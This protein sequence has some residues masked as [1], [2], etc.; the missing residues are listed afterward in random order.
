MV[1]ARLTPQ[2]KDAFFA[3]LD[4]LST[5]PSFPLHP[6]VASTAVLP[7]TNLTSRSLLSARTYFESRPEIFGNGSGSGGNGTSA[8]T[9]A[10]AASVVSSALAQSNR[11]SAAPS[12]TNGWKKPDADPG[13]LDLQEGVRVLIVEK[14]S[15]DW[16]TGEINGQRGLV[17]A[18]YVKLL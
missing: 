5:T 1:F 10:A 7:R 9:R 16:W 17:P 6:S 15:D 2:D 13:D 14:T 3:L 4:E 8:A 18:A 11:N 12:V